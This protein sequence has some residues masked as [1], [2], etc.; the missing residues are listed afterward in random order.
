MYIS[1]KKRHLLLNNQHGM[2]YIDYYKQSAEQNV[3]R[4]MQIFSTANDL[5][6]DNYAVTVT[7]TLLH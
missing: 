2:H 3:Q 1:L 6:L 7:P 4:G 5:F